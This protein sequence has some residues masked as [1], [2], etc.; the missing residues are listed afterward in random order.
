MPNVTG[1]GVFLEIAILAARLDEALR[2]TIAFTAKEAQNEGKA[3]MRASQGGRQYGG[4]TAV[5]LRRKGRARSAGLYGV[6]K[7]V[8]PYRAS[9]PG[10]PPAVR[11]GGLFAALRTKFPAKNKGYLARIFVDRGAFW[12]RHLLEFGHFLKRGKR[13]K[14]QRVVGFVAARPLIKPLDAK[15]EE[16][17]RQRL[18]DQVDQFVG[19]VAK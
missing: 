15:Y 4:G 9:A 5:T 16:I 7:A 13:G 3:L 6:R 10:Q 8:G 17:L 18:Q 11:S 2:K 1:G 14:A 12:Q 19:P